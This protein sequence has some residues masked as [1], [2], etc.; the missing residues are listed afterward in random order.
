MAEISASSRDQATGVQQ[1]GESM[2]NMD[3]T[4]LQNAAM[5]EEISAAANALRTQ[6][7]ELVGAVSVFKVGHGSLLALR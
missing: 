4:T 2:S 1:L 3:Q 7:N 5:V 6:A